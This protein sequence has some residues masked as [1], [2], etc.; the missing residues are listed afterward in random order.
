MEA[1]RRG[2]R[3]TRAA[4][5]WQR[6]PVPSRPDASHGLGGADRGLLYGRDREQVFRK[7][8]Q[9]HLLG[10]LDGFGIVHGFHHPYFS[11]LLPAPLPG[12]LFQPPTRLAE[13]LDHGGKLRILRVVATLVRLP[14][15]V[16]HRNGLHL[17]QG[18]HAPRRDRDA[19][20]GG[21]RRLC[22]HEPQLPRFLQILHVHRGDLEPA[23]RGGGRGAVPGAEGHSAHWHL[24][25]HLPLAHLHH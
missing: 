1:A 8:D 4:D 12:G 16:H 23:S 21:R 11:L 20:Q 9:H 13:S 17:G 15:D 10:G 5:W 18:H 6:A 25:L 24:V 19:A 2:R 14:D 22:H 3:Q 7:D